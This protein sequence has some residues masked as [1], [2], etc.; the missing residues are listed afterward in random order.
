MKDDKGKSLKDFQVYLNINPENQHC[1]PSPAKNISIEE[2]LS[3]SNLGNFEPRFKVM[4]KAL[5]KV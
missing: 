2:P 4:P 3:D 5:P 1:S